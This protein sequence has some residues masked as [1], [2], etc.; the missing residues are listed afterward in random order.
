[1]SGHHH[2]VTDASAVASV[3]LELGADRGA[4]AIYT[5]GEQCGREIHVS[6]VDPDGAADATAVRTHAAVRV[7]AVRPRPVYGALIPDLP[8]GRYVVWDGEVALS[9]VDVNGGAV[10][11]FEWPPVPRWPSAE[12]A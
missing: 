6:R 10:A 1:M 4:L 3:V 11:E 8:A 7:R 5:G 2:H 12:E 9:T